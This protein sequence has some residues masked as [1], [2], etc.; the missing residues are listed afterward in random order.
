M[1]IVNEGWAWPRLAYCAHYFI[2]PDEA[3]SAHQLC[4]GKVML[5][6]PAWRTVSDESKCKKCVAMLEENDG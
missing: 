1:S 5:M 3:H 6:N 2:R 4:G